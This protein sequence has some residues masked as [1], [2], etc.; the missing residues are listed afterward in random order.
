[1][2]THK[3]FKAGTVSTLLLD[4]TFEVRGMPTTYSHICLAVSLLYGGALYPHY[5]LKQ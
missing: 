1:M 3:A 5:C 2:L 4:C